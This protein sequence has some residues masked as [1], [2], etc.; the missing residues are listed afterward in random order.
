M[1]VSDSQGPAG[2]GPEKDRLQPSRGERSKS[3]AEVLEKK[4]APDKK[5][6]TSG[7]GKEQK[8]LPYRKLVPGGP[9]LQ[10]QAAVA[11]AA[12]AAAPDSGA[13]VIEAPQQAGAISSA[14]LVEGLVQEI[15][16]ATG[17]ADAQSVDIQFNSQVLQ[18]LQVHLSRQGDAV[19]I[20]F[21]TASDSVSRLLSDHIGRLSEGLAARGVTV[22]QIQVQ[23]APAVREWDFSPRSETGDRGRGNQR[24][25]GQQRRQR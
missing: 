12:F 1:R 8:G 25:G 9:D 10:P 19:S 13:P 4:A 22:G 14:A 11:A 17:P 18:G 24:Q 15:V 20:R 5:V 21:S 3:F 16:V 2:A 6:G 7:A 23:S